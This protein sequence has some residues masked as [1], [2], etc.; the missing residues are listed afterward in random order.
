MK[1]ILTS[2]KIRSKLNYILQDIVAQI[3]TFKIHE[4]FGESRYTDA[5]PHNLATI[6]THVCTEKSHFYAEFL[7]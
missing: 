7:D 5:K 4:D 2:A 6:K 1:R 3:L